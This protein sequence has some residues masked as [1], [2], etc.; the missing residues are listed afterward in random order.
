MPHEQATRFSLSRACFDYAGGL[1]PPRVQR[2]SA[3]SCI[4]RY[5]TFMRHKLNRYITRRALYLECVRS[6]AVLE[7]DRKAYH[8]AVVTPAS[9]AELKSLTNSSLGST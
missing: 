2:G 3:A 4:V 9:V 5:N 7:P 1:A 8:T 6:V